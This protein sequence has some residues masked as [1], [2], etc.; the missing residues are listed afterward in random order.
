MQKP[1]WW[2]TKGIILD[3]VGSYCFDLFKATTAHSQGG[4]LTFA[5]GTA[6]PI[7]THSA[8]LYKHGTRVDGLGVN[9]L[10]FG[11]S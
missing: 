1:F 7:A 9:Q 4:R 5:A 10:V 11:P 8:E 6:F 3:L 2:I